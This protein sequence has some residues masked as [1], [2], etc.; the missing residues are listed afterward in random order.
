MSTGFRFTKNVSLDSIAAE[1][2][3]RGPENIKK[4]EKVTS[5]MWGNDEK[6]FQE[7]FYTWEGYS[8]SIGDY[9]VLIEKGSALYTGQNNPDNC[10][11]KSLGFRIKLLKGKRVVKTFKGNDDEVMNVYECIN[12]KVKEY[13]DKKRKK[14]S[15][16][17]N[18]VIERLTSQTPELWERYVKNWTSIP[19]NMRATSFF[20]GLEAYSTK[21]E[22]S[23]V[24]LEEKTTQIGDLVGGCGDPIPYPYSDP[25]VDYRMKLLTDGKIT[26]VFEGEDYA[27]FISSSIQLLRGHHKEKQEQRQAQ[28]N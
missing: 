17:F 15:I 23:E 13:E 1:L 28:L 27:S 25:S 19:K 8:T 24:V 20:H 3:T 5:R 10:K 22:G 2:E 18:S 26:K 4:S 7:T 11:Q 16:Y 12:A 9:S 21:I 14:D 6:G